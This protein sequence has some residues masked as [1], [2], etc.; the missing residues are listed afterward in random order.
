MKKKDNI[1]KGIVISNKMNKTIIVLITKLVKHKVYGKYIKKKSKIYVHDEY[2]K[3]K[4][5]DIVF[6]KEFRPLSK[7]KSWILY[8]KVK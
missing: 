4:I 5:G 6:I 8:K 7:N 3:C 2:N 1:K